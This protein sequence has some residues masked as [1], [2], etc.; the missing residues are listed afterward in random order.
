MTGDFARGG[1]RRVS[2]R[3]LGGLLRRPL[4]PRRL[5]HLGLVCLITSCR[6]LDSEP[7]VPLPLNAPE[8]TQATGISWIEMKP[9][10]VPTVR[11]SLRTAGSYAFTLLAT[12]V[13]RTSPRTPLVQRT[14]HQ[15][16]EA[17][18]VVILQASP[19]FASPRDYYLECRFTH[20]TLSPAG[21]TQLLATNW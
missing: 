8:F 16:S 5:L 6:S 4:P 17:D 21:F 10:P 14:L 1:G 20:P 3:P 15:S 7:F 12:P 18:Q 9:T 2:A 13:G 11:I 19:R